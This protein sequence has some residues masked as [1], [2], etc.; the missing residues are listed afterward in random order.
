MNIT[1]SE[2]LHNYLQ[3]IIIESL[4]F[5]SKS[6]KKGTHVYNNASDTD[7]L[8]IVECHKALSTCPVYAG[9]W[10]QYKEVDAG[11]NVIADHIYSTI[12]QFIQGIANAESMIPWEILNGGAKLYQGEII[13][14]FEARTDSR[15]VMG[16]VWYTNIM[17][18]FK[19]ARGFLG[20]ARRD[21]KDASKLFNHDKKKCKKKCKFALKAVCHAMGIMANYRDNID[22]KLHFNIAI[23][24]LNDFN[25]FKE[26]LE[27]ANHNIDTLRDILTDM[28][29]KKVIPYT[30][31][32]EG[33]LVLHEHYLKDIELIDDNEF[34]TEMLR[35]YYK[36][37]IDNE[38]K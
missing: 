37:A 17:D 2:E 22:D 24:H 6:S 16:M 32:G 29:N 4:I 30:I 12:P 13:D 38:Y 15:S 21:I 10:L 9:H 1:I 27:K 19:S 18:N 35:L 36:A 20:L 7:Y 3:T 11:G 25:T 26:F 5:G 14:T 34:S 33:M 23:D 28:N 8:H 31:S